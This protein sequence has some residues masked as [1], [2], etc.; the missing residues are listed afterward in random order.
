MSE[1]SLVGVRSPRSVALVRKLEHMRNMSGV[2][3]QLQQRR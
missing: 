1:Q 2:F 3:V